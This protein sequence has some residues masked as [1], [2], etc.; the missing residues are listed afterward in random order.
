MGL[1]VE[2]INFPLM[3]ENSLV[4]WEMVKRGLGVT[5]MMD[6]IAQRDSDIVPILS[7]FEPFTFPI[8]LVTHRELHTSR[9][10]R[11]VFDI[12]AEELVKPLCNQANAN[13]I[14]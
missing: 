2:E 12:L 4:V 8:W 11:I 5:I 7:D 3:S 1:P 14:S 13:A 9:R 6:D 10:F